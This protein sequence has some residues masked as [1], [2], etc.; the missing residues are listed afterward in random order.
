M[1]ITK[2][3]SIELTAE[4]RTNGIIARTAREIKKLNKETNRMN[5][6]GTETATTYKK[7]LGQGM[8]EITKVTD[9]VT[10]SG[11]KYTTV[12]KG[13]QE[14]HQRFNMNALGVMFAGMALNRMMTNLNATSREWVGMNELMSTAM[15]VVTLPATMNLLEFGIIPLFEALTSLPEG[16][17]LAI[18]TVI[19]GLE[20]LGGVMMIG[21][22]LML[23]LE[24]TVNLLAKMGGGSAMAGLSKITGKLSSIAKFAA[25]GILIAVAIKDLEEGQ[26]IAALGDG[27]AVA[28]IL[29]GGKGGLAMMA[30]GVT[31]KLLGDEDFLVDVLKV[32]YKI[33]R[34]LNSIIKEA[35]LSGFSFRDFNLD[36]V[37][38]FANIERAFGR[39]IEEIQQEDA[40]KGIFDF[41]AYPENMLAS[42]QEDIDKLEEELKDDIINKEEYLAKL[43]PL[44]AEQEKILKRWQVAFEKNSEFEAKD[45]DKTVASGTSFGNSL[46]DFA[47]LPFN[48]F[49]LAKKPIENIF[50]SR[51]IGGRINKTGKYFLHEG[52]QVINKNQ[53][54]SG[55]V[56]QVTYNVTVS[57]K[58]EFEQMLRANNDKLTS[59][60]RR[61]AK[62]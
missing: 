2:E 58:R 43:E 28:G 53:T 23:G 29:I 35:V 56:M 22:Q 51:A 10:S 61:M 13:I 42:V 54:G 33:G 3:I 44:V 17:K 18:G 59:D 19:T 48:P 12:Q 8:E 46:L 49:G 27:L 36:N 15:G 30:V 50:G 14:Q 52:E 20:G 25:V 1:G 34:T 31:L 47:M 41:I 24:S 32:G 62:V 6:I 38:G 26:V 57:D 21:G 55:V 37:E 60:V 4:D 5:K 45:K 39:A 16:A 40:G 9:K 7:D 11:K